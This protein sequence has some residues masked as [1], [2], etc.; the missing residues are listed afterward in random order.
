MGQKVGH[1]PDKT[2]GSQQSKEG[3]D[4]VHCSEFTVRILSERV[5]M[6]ARRSDTSRTKLKGRNNRR[7]VGHCGEAWGA[8]GVTLVAGGRGGGCDVA[9]GGR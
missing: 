2:K 5:A 4:T 3:W 7:R 6:W 8:A 1:F 9:E